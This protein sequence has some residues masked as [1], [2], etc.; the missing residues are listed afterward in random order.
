MCDGC[1]CE[2]LLHGGEEVFLPCEEQV[3]HAL[4]HVPVARKHNGLQECQH[5]PH[6]V[7]I[8]VGQQGNHLVEAGSQKSKYSVPSN[9]MCIIWS[10]NSD[11]I[12]Y[13]CMY[14]HLT[15]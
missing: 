8:A 3:F 7:I 15:H 1:V 6:N 5:L 14:V 2:Q 10:T 13:H 11:T 9:Y 12:E 4:L